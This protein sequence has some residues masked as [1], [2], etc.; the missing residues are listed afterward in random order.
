M[1]QDV[2]PTL[3]NIGCGAIKLDGWIGVDAY[4]DPD[5]RHDLNV[6][7]WPFKDNSVDKILAA[8]VFEHLENWW[9]AF[10]ECVRILK[11]YGLLDFRVP[12]DSSSTALTYRDHLH[13]FSSNSFYGIEGT[14]CGTN[15]WAG[16]QPRLPMRIVSYQLIPFREYQRI[17]NLFP[18]IGRWLAIHGRNFIHEQRFIFEK[19]PPRSTP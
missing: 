3:L 15:N 10:E 11:P 4:G 17:F 6:I 19:L 5:V 16:S 18:R 13:V 14:R 12:H 9:G 1:G 7:P 8:H 2:P